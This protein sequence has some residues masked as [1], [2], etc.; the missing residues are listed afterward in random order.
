M[1]LDHYNRSQEIEIAKGKY[2]VAITWKDGWKKIIRE[3]WLK[4]K[5]Q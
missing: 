4:R 5:S 3:L 1:A 2:K